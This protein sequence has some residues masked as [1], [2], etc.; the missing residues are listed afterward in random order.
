MSINVLRVHLAV[1]MNSAGF[2]LFQ[3]V[4]F[5][6]DVPDS[7]DTNMS[8]LQ[9]ADSLFAADIPICIGALRFRMIVV[10]PHHLAIGL[11]PGG[12]VVAVIA[13][14]RDLIRNYRCTGQP[15]SR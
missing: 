8:P 15:I 3:T 13:F 6:A 1:A 14:G 2:D 5:L 12:R 9:Q 10:L 11:Y 4:R 7:F